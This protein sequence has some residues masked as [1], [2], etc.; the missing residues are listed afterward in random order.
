MSR[1]FRTLSAFALAFGIMTASMPRANA[2]IILAPTGVGLIFI[3]VGIVH[4]NLTLLILDGSNSQSVVEKALSEKYSF[5][6]DQ[7]AIKELSAEIAK[8]MNEVGA[9]TEETEI[10]LDQAV[11]LEILAPTGLL[12]LEPV[13]VSQLINELT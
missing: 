7:Q 10:K 1:L 2:G 9:V 3:I 5:I 4:D 12:E 11:I 6:D 8:K 13:K